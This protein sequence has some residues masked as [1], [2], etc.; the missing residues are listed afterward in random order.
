VSVV[1]YYTQAGPDY[2]AWSRRFNMHFGFWRPGIDPRDREAMLE[3]MNYEVLQRVAPRGVPR[4]LLDLGCGLGATSRAAAAAFPEAEVT[5]ISLVEWQV[6]QARYLTETGLKERIRFV[7]G[8]FQQMPFPDMYFDAAF[9]LESS[10]YAHGADK[11]PLLEESYRVLRPGGM[12]VIADALLRREQIRNP[13]TRLAHDLLCRSWALPTMG[14]LGLVARRLEEIGFEDITVEDISWNVAPSVA[15]VPLVTLQFFARELA[16]G[17][18]PT[19]P[20]R[21]GNALAS[22]PLL[23]FGLD[24]VASGY[25]LISARRKS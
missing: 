21:L 16:R 1:E 11:S 12:L 9:A 13:V 22:L 14:T 20:H 5:G 18:F 10:C 17:R 8:D 7:Q 25:F 23:V 24:R 4:R 6:E 19:N 15:H 3:R 2:A